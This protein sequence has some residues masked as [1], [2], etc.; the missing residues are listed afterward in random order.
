MIVVS[1]QVLPR[2]PVAGTGVA[3]GALVG[4]AVGFAVGL[5]VGAVVGLAVG[6]VEGF[7]DGAAVTAVLGAGTTL[8]AG[9][10]LADAPAANARVP[11][12][13]R[14]IVSASFATAYVFARERAWT[15]RSAIDPSGQNAMVDA[16]SSIVRPFVPVVL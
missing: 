3:L 8:A 1:C 13:S 9:A 11:S 15:Y 4:A 14:V 6:A 12:S 16:P 7:A 10:V 5:A 2:R